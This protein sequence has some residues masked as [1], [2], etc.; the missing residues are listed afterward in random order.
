MSNYQEMNF[1][2]N[3]GVL[4]ILTLFFL[5]G[6]NDEKSTKEEGS[7]DLKVKIDSIGERYIHDGKVMGLS[8]AVVKADSILYN[9]SFGYVD[10]LKSVS[11]TNDHYFL[12]A[13]ISKLV[14]STIVMKLVEEGVL[15]LDDKLSD[16]LPDYPNKKQAEKIKLRHLI[17]MTSGLKE[18]ATT[19][20]SIYIA[21]GKSPSK[22]DYYRFLNSHELEFEPGSHYKYVNSGFVLMAMIVER[23]TKKSFQSNIDRIINEPTGFNIELISERL[24]NPMMSQY[25]QLNKGKISKRKHW[26][27]I[28]GDGGM[29]N[30]ALQLA[31]YPTK[32]MDGTIIT[33]KSFEQ[34]ISDTYLS[35]GYSSEYGLGVKNGS[36]EGEPMFGHS[37]GDATTYSMMFHFPKKST[38]IVAMINTNNTP[39]N[40]RQIFSETALIV[41][42]KGRPDFSKNERTNENLI[43]F[44]G[45]YLSPG[46]PENGTAF[47]VENNQNGHLY[48]TFD[49]NPDN[50]QR[51][52]S[53]GNGMFWIKK[54]PYDRIQFVRDNSNNVVALKEFYGGYM[55]KIRPKIAAHN[56][57]KE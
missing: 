35:S 9:N 30:T 45:A 23:A 55:S 27:W 36:F 12:M 5:Y 42:D 25:F 3:Y 51:M 19:I 4:L 21:T 49:K 2:K 26:P 44:L 40:A 46:D 17:S 32:W 38:T 56:D 16:L 1:L 13:S 29:T 20:D 34:M 14:G 15:D 41:L 54:W 8:I 48:Y 24:K 33:P 50:G 7:S 31:K 10:S 43:D 47:I 11:T 37:G 39:A 57:Q 28:K 6:C 22:Q 52:Y 18:Y 53:L